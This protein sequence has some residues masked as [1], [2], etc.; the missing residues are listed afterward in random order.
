MNIEL[1][2]GTGFI[3]Q[4]PYRLPNRLKQAVEGEIKELLKAAIIEESESAWPSPLVPV[5]KPNGKIRLCIDFRKLNL[6]TPQQQ[7]Y[8]PCLR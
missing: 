8:I 5:A 6:A 1:Q 3:S 4:M 2:E 7:T